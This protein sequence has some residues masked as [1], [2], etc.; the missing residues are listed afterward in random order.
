MLQVDIR[1]GA[2]RVQISWQ[3]N[4]HFNALLNIHGRNHSDG[5]PTLFRGN[6]IKQGTSE[7]VSGFDRE[8][9]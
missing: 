3:P 4:N 2:A 5:S 8:K 9:L 7:L 6:V 1:S